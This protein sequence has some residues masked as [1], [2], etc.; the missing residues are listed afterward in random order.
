MEIVK[1]IDLLHELPPPRTFYKRIGKRIVDFVFALLLLLVL[2]PLLLLILVALLLFQGGNPFFLQERVGRKCLPFRIIKFRTMRNTCGA[3]GK[4]LPDEERTTLVGKFLRASSLD[5]LP[6][7]L[8]VLTGDM[9]FI[10][11]RPWIPE[12]MASFDAATRRLRMRIRPGISG[13]AQVHGR[14]NLTFRQRVAFDLRYSR[15]L[16]MWLDIRILFRT[17][18]KVAL[19][20]GIAQRVDALGPVPSA[21]AKD[22]ETK[23]LRGNKPR[24]FSQKISTL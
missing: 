24:R 2:S 14:N 10:G 18:W 9:S 21:P 17:F 4:L 23:G 1:E 15:Q 16:S 11:P 19:S 6:E 12:Q 20:E 5:E 13:L 22:P 7:L 3:D 8:N